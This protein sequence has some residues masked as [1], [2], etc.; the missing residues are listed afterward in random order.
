M[1]EWLD[2]NDGWLARDINNNGKIDNATELFGETGGTSAYAK[3]AALDSNKDGKL[4]SVDTAYSTLR[5]WQDSNQNGRTDAGELKT[6]GELKITSVS[7]KQTDARYLDGHKVA[8]TSSF[9]INGVTRQAADV[10]LQTD[11]LNS[12]YIGN[13]SGNDVKVDMETLVGTTTLITLSA[14][15]P[16]PSP[17]SPT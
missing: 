10:L 7:L 8:G 1:V 16:S 12:W 13:G 14:A 17:A 11:Q 9:T 5:I 4:T 6:L 3:L 2:K 15:T